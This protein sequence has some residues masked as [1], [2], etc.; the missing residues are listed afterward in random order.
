VVLSV[1][2]YSC[3]AWALKISLLTKLRSFH[4]RCVRAIAGVNMWKVREFR[5][6]CEEVLKKVGLRT[7]EVYIH[8]R[9][10]R[11]VGHVSRMPWSRLPRKL[12]SAWCGVARPASGPEYRWG[13][14][15]ERALSA[16][17]LGVRDWHKVAADRVAWRELVGG[18]GEDKTR[19]DVYAKTYRTSRRSA[20]A[21]AA[22]GSYSVIAAPTGVSYGPPDPGLML[23]G[24]V[25]MQNQPS[26]ILAQYAV[27]K[28]AWDAYH[29]PQ[30]NATAAA[31]TA[32][33]TTQAPAAPAAPAGGGLRSVHGPA[34]F[35]I[36]T[37]ADQQRR[38][39]FIVCST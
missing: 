3:E 30:A 16:V 6:T 4:N 34:G 31:T 22:S 36:I 26:S 23:I 24:G 39:R 27:Q 14:G 8:R 21:R 10:L 32:A 19:R 9:Q 33:N 11:W 37:S 1:L 12:M 18:H 7:I 25:S 5:I 15:V 13:D 17:K 28:R 29:S 38:F 2:L 20:R 35:S